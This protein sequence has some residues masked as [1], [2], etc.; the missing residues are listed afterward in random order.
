MGLHF[1]IWLKIHY[2]EN[3][4]KYK[5]RRHIR[6]AKNDLTTTK[7][8]LQRKFEV[9]LSRA[10]CDLLFRS[11]YFSHNCVNFPD[12]VCQCGFRSQTAFHVIFHCPLLAD[13]RRTFLN[14]IQ[15]IPLFNFTAFK[16]ASVLVNMIAARYFCT[17]G[18]TDHRNKQI[19]HIE[20]G[21][22]SFWCHEYTKLI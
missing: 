16:N 1:Q 21:L 5:L 9:T 17:D 15:S 20:N 2:L 3:S 11:H 14:E 10:R 7:L 18:Q 13:A 19:N 12:P 4:F 6:V 8:N 22:L